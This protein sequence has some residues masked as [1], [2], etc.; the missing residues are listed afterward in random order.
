VRIVVEDVWTYLYGYKRGMFD[1]VTSW[2]DPN[3]FFIKSYKIGTWDGRRRLVR[4]HRSGKYFYML[5]G[6]LSRVID[7]MNKK[8]IKYVL[9]DNRRLDPVENNPCYELLDKDSGTIRLDQ[10]RY[11]FQADAVDALLMHG[12]GLLEICTG[13]GKTIIGIAA[14]KTLDRPTVWL[15][16]RLNLM[17]QTQRQMQER[18]GVKV[19]IVGD[20]KIEY[21]KFTVGMIQSCV[22]EKHRKFLKTREVVVGDEVHH[23]EADQ[24]MKVFSGISAPYRLGLSATPC[25]IGNGMNLIAQTGDIVYSLAPKEAIEM[26]VLVPPRIWFIPIDTPKVPAKTPF[27]TVYKDCVTDNIYRNSLAVEVSQQFS[28]EMKSN[29]LL[30]NRI[31]HGKTL[32]SMMTQAGL[33]SEFVYGKVRTES[34]DAIF[35]DLFANRIDNVVAIS[36]IVGEGSDYPPLRAMINCTGGKGGGDAADEDETGRVLIQ[37]IGRGLRPFPGKT[38]FDYVDFADSGHRFVKD[39]GRDRVSTLKEQGYAEYIRPWSEYAVSAV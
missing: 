12:R 34:R 26:G 3:R 36:E 27:P 13:G 7:L 2:L 4:K 29:L 1:E 23:L 20:S 6:L 18:L 10:G 15:T 11:S 9:E 39:A 8:G 16:H 17:Y 30:V 24:W 14:I 31:K 25:L 19:G 21:E 35:E 22:S 28:R 33:K 37:F 38:H 32:K 5:S